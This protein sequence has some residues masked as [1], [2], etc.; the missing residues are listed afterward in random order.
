[1]RSLRGRRTRRRR[2]LASLLVDHAAAAA[3]GAALR[4]RDPRDRLVPALRSGLRAD[5]RRPRRCHPDRRAAPVRGRLPELLPVRRRLGH[6][7]GALRDHPRLLHPAVPPAARSHGILSVR[8]LDRHGLA[9]T[10]AL[11]VLA[12]VWLLPI[13]WVVVTSFKITAD[14]VKLPP[15]WIPW[16]VTLEHYHEVLLSSSRT[17]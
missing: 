1:A 13:V 10:L 15:E 3:A 8:G 5:R 4:H 12:L 6:G 2:R 14:I 17:A 9:L 7:L 11:G 16:P